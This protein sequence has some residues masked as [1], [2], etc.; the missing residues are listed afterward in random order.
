MCFPT[1]AEHYV[2]FRSFIFHLSGWIMTEK[3]GRA[4][5]VAVS[6]GPASLFQKLT[7]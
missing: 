4:P 3:G 5:I 6:A 1:I 7:D 2:H